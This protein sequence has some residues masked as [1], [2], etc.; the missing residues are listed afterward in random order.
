MDTSNGVELHKSDEYLMIEG[1]N[2]D[3]STS[4]TSSD[5]PTQ[6]DLQKADMPSYFK[7]KKCIFLECTGKV[8]KKKNYTLDFFKYGMLLIK[9]TYFQLWQKN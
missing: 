2:N 3:V 9:C 5:F 1:N 7:K 4:I 8:R 6:T